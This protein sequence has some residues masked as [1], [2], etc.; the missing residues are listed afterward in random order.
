[1][2][3]IFQDLATESGSGGK[4]YGVECDLERDDDIKNLFDFIRNH[5]EL[6]QVDVCI[7]NAGDFLVFK[8][9]YLLAFY[10]VVLEN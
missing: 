1:M 2:C 3:L 10:Q 9:N 6:G 4:F 8:K 5:A 7:C